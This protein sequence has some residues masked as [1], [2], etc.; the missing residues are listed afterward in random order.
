MVD[1]HRVLAISR[2]AAMVLRD[3]G[4]VNRY[5]NQGYTRIDPFAVADAANLPV[6]LR[7]LQDL[8]GAF[9]RESQAGILVNAE[10]PPGLVH[11][12][13]AH[14]LG[15]YFLGHQTTTDR[16]LDYGPNADPIEKEAD[17]FAYQ[18]LM[19]RN[20]IADIMQ[21]KGWTGEALRDPR[22]VYQLSL[23]LGT[24]YTATVWTLWRNGILQLSLDET[25]SLARIQLQRLKREIA[26]YHGDDT[27][28]D[29]WV[30]DKDDRDLIFEPRPDD[31]FIVELPSH[32]SSGFLWSLRD[33]ADA[34]FTL[35]PI[36]TS[37][38]NTTNFTPDS[39]IVIGGSA[40]LQY[41]L[42]QSDDQDHGVRHALNFEE[43][44]PWR[45]AESTRDRFTTCAEFEAIRPGLNE[46]TRNR[47]V[48]EVASL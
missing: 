10:R 14:E 13:C 31:R 45:E 40:T 20:L 39:P 16:D 43:L 5:R 21:R 44:Q 33:A 17:L 4:A 12:T 3:T 42:K 46:Q 38:V 41:A 2:L 23:R 29:V 32:A 26:D 28:S 8:L 18:L 27:I 48:N 15:H 34:G 9:L 36:T 22:V 1:R 7:P 19:P 47:L 25:R 11:M 30:L 35:H 24:S 6:M 37:A